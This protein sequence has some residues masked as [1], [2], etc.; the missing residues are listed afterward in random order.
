MVALLYSWF[1]CLFL[2]FNAGVSTFSKP[3]AGAAHPFYVS[4]VEIN[5]NSSDKTLEISCKL[6]ADDMEDVLKQQFKTSVDLTS[7]NQQAQNNKLITAY[8]QAHLQVAADDKAQKLQY[9]GFEKESESVYCYFEVPQADAPKKLTVTNSLLH[10]FTKSQI[11]IIHVMA[12][13]QRKSHKLD[14]P[15]TAVSFTF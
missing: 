12:N 14:Y 8:V 11:N 5:H 4:V 6:F 9:V 3:H 10:D 15:N 13:G 2:F 1:A 7:N